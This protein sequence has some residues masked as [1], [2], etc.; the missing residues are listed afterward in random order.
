L[1]LTRHAVTSDYIQTWQRGGAKLCV[2][3]G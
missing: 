3:F 1:S 2:S